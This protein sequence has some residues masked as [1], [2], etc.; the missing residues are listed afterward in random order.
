MADTDSQSDS[1]L[2]RRNVLI[3]VGVTAAC[4]IALA[5]PRIKPQVMRRTREMI[6]RTPARIYLP[7]DY[8]DY[9][10]WLSA[11]G[12]IFVAEGGY[13]L[14]LAGVEPLGPAG[15]RPAEVARDR[16]FQAAFDVRNGMTMAGGLI[17]TLVHPTHGRI[18]LLMTAS[19]DPAMVNRM[20]A[21]MN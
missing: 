5:A 9:P 20:Y 12:N 17:Y 15:S 8:G 7:L 1:V 21:V 4:G 6:A 11:V 18:P 16:A 14:R 10:E 13:Q 3:G 2:T 19:T